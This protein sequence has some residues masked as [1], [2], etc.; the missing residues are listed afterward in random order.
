VIAVSFCAQLREEARDIWD[1]W[2]QH[3][4]ITG[5]GDGSLERE[6]FVYWI[7]QD[8]L[9]LQDY[10]RVMALA[11]A[12]ANNL[13]DMQSFAR[14]MDGILNTEMDL[15][16]NY[17]ARFGITARELDTLEKVPTCQ[18]YTDFLVR[19]AALEPVGVTVAALL[20]C[21]WGFYEIGTRLQAVGN[22]GPDNPY[23]DWIAM[24]SSPEFARLSQWSKELMEKYAQQAG[25]GEREQMKKAFLIS[26][27]YESLFWE[28]AHTL[29][30]WKF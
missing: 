21:I 26:S 14:L 13:A 12:K 2:H 18:A 1:G 9:Y 6:K 22:T 8:Y 23:R 15:H 25:A 4:F 16:R 3:P 7:K 17:C 29:E 10:A 30:G 11:G 27:K 28:M 24:Y 19:T 20:P 5:I